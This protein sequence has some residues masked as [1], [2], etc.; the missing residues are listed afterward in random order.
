[1]LALASARAR[2]LVP[3]HPVIQDLLLMHILIVQNVA[4]VVDR[5]P[6]D[7]GLDGYISVGIVMDPSLVIVKIFLIV[8]QNGGA[9]T[10]RPIIVIH[11]YR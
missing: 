1:M 9:N 6:W 2:A 10:H 5:H 11:K 4:P 8:L 7:I 3:L